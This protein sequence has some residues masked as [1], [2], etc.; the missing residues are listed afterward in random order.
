MRLVY[1]PMKLLG[2]TTVKGLEWLWCYTF[3]PLLIIFK[4]GNNYSP[5]LSSFL[6]IILRFK[7]C[8]FSLPNV[9]ICVEY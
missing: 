4:V 1:D 2:V 7:I 3:P 9:K 5:P 8:S 6:N